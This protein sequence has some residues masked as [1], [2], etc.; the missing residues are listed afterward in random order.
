MGQSHR[1]AQVVG[2][3]GRIQSQRETRTLER[4]IKWEDPEPEGDKGIGE[5]DEEAVNVEDE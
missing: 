2:L 5:E 3:S 1:V 4:R